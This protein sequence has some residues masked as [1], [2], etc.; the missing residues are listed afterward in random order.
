MLSLKGKGQPT[1]MVCGTN[2]KCLLLQYS[3]RQDKAIYQADLWASH[4]VNPFVCKEVTQ[5]QACHG[6]TAGF[7]GQAGGWGLEEGRSGLRISEE[8]ACG[9]KWPHLLQCELCFSPSSPRSITFAPL[10]LGLWAV[11][12]RRNSVQAHRWLLE[13]TLASNVPQWA[14]GNRPVHKMCV[15]LPENMLSGVRVP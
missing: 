13:Q 4:L 10:G 1:S 14:H 5:D 6:I 9:W 2:Q 3:P 7:N 8:E 12:Q 15:I 11:K